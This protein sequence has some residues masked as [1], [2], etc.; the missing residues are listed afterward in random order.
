MA[1]WETS[2]YVI[3]VSIC[4]LILS[5]RTNTWQNP[6]CVIVDP[7]SGPCLDVFLRYF[8]GYPSA[9][10]AGELVHHEWV[11]YLGYVYDYNDESDTDCQIRQS[12]KGNEE[13][14]NVTWTRDGFSTCTQ[15]DVDNFNSWW[16]FVCA[17]HCTEDDNC[18]RYPIFFGQHLWNNCSWDVDE[19]KPSYDLRLP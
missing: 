14:T 18:R 15:R 19:E 16:D 5:V 6:S 17:G 2:F 7:N 10:G 11:E 1:S 8:R 12:S 3:C 13:F 4:V 9:I